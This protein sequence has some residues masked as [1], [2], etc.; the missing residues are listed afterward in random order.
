MVWDG[1]G[2]FVG[3]IQCWGDG[4][5]DGKPSVVNPAQ[6][7]LGPTAEQATPAELADPE[8]SRLAV[9]ALRLMA[10]AVPKATLGSLKKRHLSGAEGAYPWRDVTASINSHPVDP[11]ELAQ[12][13]VRAQRDWVHRGGRKDP[14]KSMRNR[15]KGLVA[16]L[17]AK[18]IFFALFAA[19]SVALLVLLKHG[20][21]DLDIYRIL[22][23]V[24]P[25]LPDAGG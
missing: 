15:G 21:P 24:G 13:A 14:G 22:E 16:N 11:Q 12:H 10:D 1:C 4:D 19:A 8:L 7:E 17:L 18:L 9:A 25:W 5:W 23:W 20:W 3:R 6:D 2:T